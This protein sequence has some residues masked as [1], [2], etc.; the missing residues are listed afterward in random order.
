MKTAPRVR[1]A[2]SPTGYLHIGGARTALFNWLWA[3]QNDGVFVLRIEDT[4]RDRST[5]ESVNA[6]LESMAWLGLDW[7]EGPAFGD[8][9]ERGEYGPYYQMQRLG[10]Y[11]TFAE[12]LIALNAA[13]RCYCTKEELAAAREAHGK[14][15]QK[16]AFRYPGTCRDRKDQPDK[17]FTVRLRAPTTGSTGWADKVKG[18]IDVPNKAQQDVVLMRADGV[19]LYNFG[20]VVDDISMG[21]NLIARGDDHVVNTP[22]QILLF[23][24]LDTRVPDF[25]HLP[26][27]L[28][29]NGEKLSKRHAAVSV[30]D[31][32]DKGFLPDAVLNYLARLG[33]SHGDQEIFTR[34]EMIKLFNWEACGSSGS[35]YD[36]KK[37]M[38]VQSSHLRQLDSQT[39]GKLAHPYFEAAHITPDAQRL[40]TAIDTVK[41]R[42]ET[43][44]D[45]P[46]MTDFYFTDSFPMDEKA[47]EK[48]LTETHKALLNNYLSFLSEQNDF[49]K[50]ALES[51]TLAWL[52]AQ[53]LSL[54]DIAQPA[55]V[56][57]TGRTQSP[58]LFEMIEVLGR[59]TTLARLTKASA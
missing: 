47:K 38:Y 41:T 44:V 50:G 16:T 25:A 4:D 24:A 46:A 8:K 55:R 9:P 34:D 58:G 42:A 12:R 43:L 6:I 17:P 32:R 49:S 59:D 15:G 40:P 57:L 22:V 53:G 56:A 30:L 11:Q 29:P 26:M 39:L 27:I 20:A 2:P 1:F 14:T 48:F 10:V 5:A 45:I 23:Q 52:N 7:D 35:K 37:F 51:A 36:V 19:P 21:I 28:A 33:W 54:K 13:Y 3:R 31:Y 18:P